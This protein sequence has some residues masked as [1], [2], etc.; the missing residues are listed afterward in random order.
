MNQKYF[1]SLPLK[2]SL[3]IFCCLILMTLPQN[4][5]A[6]CNRPTNIQKTSLTPNSVSFSWTGPSTG[7][8]AFNFD[9]YVTNDLTNYPPI[10][11][12]T[13][14]QSTSST[15]ATWT[16]LNS[17]FTYRIFVRSRCIDNSTS[18]WQSGGNFTT[19]SANSGCANGPYGQNPTNIFV[20][21]CTGSAEVINTDAW[22][23]EYADIQV[24]PNRQYIFDSSRSTDYVTITN[25]AVSGV[26]SHGS[27]PHVWNSGTF[28]GVI[29]YFLNS[30]ST[31]G[32]QQSYRTRSIT[33]Q[34]VPSTCVPPISPIVYSISSN[35]AV[36][37]WSFSGSFTSTEYYVSPSSTTPTIN[38]TPSGFEQTQN[39]TT[40][41]GLTPNTTYYF[42]LRSSCGTD[43]SNWIPG[44]SFTTTSSD[45]TGCITSIYGQNPS[46]TF[47]PA[48]SGVAEIIATNSWAGEFSKVN[49]I[50][51]KTYTFTSSTTTDYITIKDDSTFYTYA[52]GPTPLVWSSGANT[53]TVR[54]MLQTNSTCNFQDVNRTTTITCT[55]AVPSCATPSGLVI[56]T[57]TAN[58]VT[59][60]WN[61]ASP[62][63]ANGYQYYIATNQNTPNAAT[64]PTGTTN[65]N[66]VTAVGLTANNTY[67]FWVRSNCANGVSQWVFGTS[68]TTLGNLNGCTTAIY[69]QYPT[70]IYSPTCLS[71]GVEELIVS[72]AYAGE[73][74]WVSV[75]SNRQYTFRSSVSSDYITITNQDASVFY[76]AGNSP[77]VWNTGTNTGNVRYYIHTNSAC[78]SENVNRSRYITCQPIVPSCGSPVAVTTS[79]ITLNAATVSWTAPVPGPASGYQIFLSTSSTAPTSTTTP[80][81][82]STTTTSTLT[83]LVP[84]TIYYVWVRSNC[85][86]GQS[87]W[88]SG[89]SFTT[90][91][92][93]C[94]APSNLSIDSVTSN[95]A[96]VSWTAAVP[97]PTQYDIYLSTFVTAPTAG[98]TPT[99]FVSSSSA[100]LINLNPNMTYYLW[101]R[102][103]CSSSQSSWV[104]GGS[105][106]T[107]LSVCNGPTNLS[108]NSITSNSAN[109]TW[110]AA[111]PS[112]T[113]YNIYLS[114]SSTAPNALTVPSGSVNA[115]TAN[116]VNLTA[117]T[118]YYFW[119]RSDCGT[120]QSGWIS[121]VSF[122][123][124]IQGDCTTAVYGQYPT[125]TFTPSCSGSSETIV[126]DAYAG[127][128]A[129]V[130][131]Q[132]NKQYTF[133][134]SVATDHITITSADGTTVYTRGTTPLVWLSGLNT[135]IIRYYIHAN[136]TCGS[137]GIDRTRSITCASVCAAPT[138]VTVSNVTT[139]QATVQ[140]TSA[141]TPF[142]YQHYIST[143]STA[144]TNL[145]AASG[146]STSTTR[147]LT[148]LTPGTV[149][150]IWGRCFC[151]PDA[152]AWVSGGS[153]TTLALAGCTTAVHGLFPA[154]TYTPTCSGANEQ[155]TN[156]AWAGEYS[157]VSISTNKEYTFTSS[158]TT[159]YI[160][161][162]NANASA[163]YAFGT[164]PLVWQS[165]S[166]SG[167]IRYFIHTDS[168]CTDQ[169]VNRSR[170]IKC[171]NAL[172]NIQNQMKHLAL[173]P[174][175]TSGILYVSNDELIEQIYIYNTL[176]QLVQQQMLHAKEAAISM[177]QLMAGTYFVKVIAGGQT[178]TQKVIKQ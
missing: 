73:F 110:S 71:S 64:T 1:F 104:S 80:T 111:V 21:S 20:P 128:Y 159:D 132:T 144:P 25:Q 177:A 127:E 11:A 76:I 29:R 87:T 56:S 147:V 24:V 163:V 12:E 46:A 90:L 112:P 31:C 141:T 105:F 99:G 140:W 2:R 120:G 44:G 82:S 156:T 8:A 43:L 88:I 53:T 98:T 9:Y 14:Y 157:N 66:S 175:P 171:T 102:S 69:G 78:G 123:T 116:F 107:S 33:C 103:D 136:A 84:Q 137:Q 91:A 146:S 36:L 134:S 178:Q 129:L 167:V 153:F 35:G 174:N 39:K 81:V 16:G 60:T 30:N 49:I 70:T 89:G 59:A 119:V 101:I 93:P 68:F 130:N 15:S 155:I 149:Y 17:N 74:N 47:T 34:V 96:H 57:I 23:G 94:N 169:N 161:I 48:C 75:N 118:T 122:T 5:L 54:F 170:F 52:S 138:S 100:D 42:W 109:I 40:L 165:G 50:P 32:T 117:S 152:S 115:L 148:G 135:G 121:G 79:G 176:G 18:D 160:T 3:F 6:Q 126:A 26:M 166:N 97:T 113:Q 65:T 19:L 133:T 37:S 145:T 95:T 92:A 4:L 86:G 7:T 13:N 58:N 151:G 28:D 106:T 61:Q 72:D 125:T 124:P 108:S 162:T 173:Y 51:N 158:V 154:T 83:N 45:P 62:V 168:N 55:N 172:S 164:S 142:A 114:S 41:T 22:A 77:L 38:T 67:Y 27:V 150:Y 10:G 139:T 143:S 63:P 85:G 131:I